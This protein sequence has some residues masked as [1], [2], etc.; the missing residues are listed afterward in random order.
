MSVRKSMR[1]T[2][3]GLQRLSNKRKYDRKNKVGHLPDM[4]KKIEN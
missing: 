4:Q 3:L 1:E 2:I